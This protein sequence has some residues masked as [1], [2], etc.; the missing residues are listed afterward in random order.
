M[1]DM[2]SQNEDT[3]LSKECPDS[4]PVEEASVG[5][6][7]AAVGALKKGPWTSAEDAILVDYVQKHG[8]GN[9]NAVQKNSGLSRCGKSCRLRWS[10]HLKPD[11]KKGP[12]TQEEEDRIIELHAKMGNKWARMAAEVWVSSLCQFHDVHISASFADILPLSLAF[13]KL[14][15]R[16]DN[17]IKNYWNT[18]LKRRQRAGL[19][20]YPPDI[21]LKTTFDENEQS[22]SSYS[23]GD[24]HHPDILHSKGF[25]IPD[26][27]FKHLD[28]NNG[29]LPYAPKNLNP[30]ASGFLGQCLSSWESYGFV[31]PT[32]FPSKRLRESE[33]SFSESCNQGLAEIDHFDTGD[34]I[35]S[36]FQ[37]SF[38]E[39]EMSTN[40][41]SPLGYF[42]GSHALLNGNT[43]SSEPNGAMKLELP[44]LQYSDTQPAIWDRPPSPLPSLE[45][46]DTVI[47]S[48]PL[49]Q[50]QSDC[51][52]PR[53][54]GLLEAL[55]YESQALKASEDHLG[56]KSSNGTTGT[57]DLADCSSQDLQDPEWEVNGGLISP[58]GHSAASAI[59]EYT[60][61]CSSS[62]ELHPVE[63]TRGYKVKPETVDHVLAPSDGKKKTA[64]Q[65]L[66]RPDLLLGSYWLGHNGEAAKE[67]ILGDAIGAIPG[68][69][70]CSD[71]EKMDHVP[72]ASSQEHG[73]DSVEWNN[74]FAD[75]QHLENP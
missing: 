64:D 40:Y 22:Q 56:N 48:P 32:M 52:S 62:D 67:S 27:K 59:S 28:L 21:C 61:I 17:E 50:T 2:T 7:T 1:S 29:F 70:L 11:L 42:S 20:V 41:V 30:P 57:G 72:S 4:P 37:L 74:M 23:L 44:S 43:S 38:F 5:V 15:G 53:S 46:V 24:T 39:P 55:I 19:P 3:M 58:I 18:R 10:N 31:F 63:A 26:I 25:E 69:K 47:Q 35:S 8:E 6:G 65:D 49:D 36:P 9:W 54:S 75:S 33:N 12:F 73:H 16:T 66:L 45:S 68:E 60:P 34:K 51:V 13:S 14:P 71:S